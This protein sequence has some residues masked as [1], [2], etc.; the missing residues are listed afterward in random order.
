METLRPLLTTYA[1]NITGS[2]EEAKDI[3]QDAYLH[4]MQADR[5][6]VRDEKAYLVRTVIN[7]SINRKK[8]QQSQA[9][10][11]PGQWLP[12]P[13]ATERADHSLLRS[14]V[15]SYSLMVLLERLNP[16]QRAV[17]ILR[18]AFDYDHADIAA[19]LNISE[20]YSRQLLARARKQLGTPNIQA[21]SDTDLAKYRDAIMR[22]D[23]ETLERL[24]N[25]DITVISDGGGKAIAALH[26][27]TG[28]KDAIALLA[29]LYK[30]MYAHLE[31]HPTFVNN[32]PAVLWYNNGKLINCQVFTFVKG[33]IS[34]VFM[35]RNPDKLSNLEK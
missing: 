28:K 9:A 13:V 27:V 12:E 2:L 31:P 25:E 24:L 34:N 33:A 11:Y 10:E 3:V 17:F 26:P 16:R 23:I 15:L 21:Y 1:Y 22:N 18:E 14:D 6:Q 29:G 20:D 5:S 19:T 7:R 32:Q 4:Y 30:K 8:Q 35:I